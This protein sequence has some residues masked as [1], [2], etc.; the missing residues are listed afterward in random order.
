MKVLDVYPKET[1]IVMEVSLTHVEQIV[2]FLDKC[3]MEYD[4]EKEPEMKEA[5]EYVDG[6]FFKALYDLVKQLKPE[7]TIEKLNDTKH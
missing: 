3:V 6:I 7:F 5:A 1:V 2:K 4:G